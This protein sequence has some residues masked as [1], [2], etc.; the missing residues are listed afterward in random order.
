MSG[1]NDVNGT[2]WNETQATK[3][4]STILPQNMTIVLDD[5]L[6]TCALGHYAFR[7]ERVT[8][9]AILLCC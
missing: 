7:G 1:A 5:S 4:S 6:R 9:C 8:D 3:I 2:E